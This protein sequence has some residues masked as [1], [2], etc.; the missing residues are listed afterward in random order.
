M[1]P[2]QFASIKQYVRLREDTTMDTLILRE[3]RADELDACA[4]M[5][6]ESFLTVAEEFGLTPE[7][8]ATNG[9]FLPVERLVNDFTNGNIMFGVFADG[10]RPVGFMQ[11]RDKGEGVFSLE[12]LCVLPGWR[13]DGIGAKLLEKART[14]AIRL[15]GHKITIGIIE[16]NTR[17][18]DWYLLNGFVHTGTID[19][20]HLPFIVG[21][22]ELPLNCREM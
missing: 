16:E 21:F 4:A 12:K 5:I 1:N 10:D 15:G 9:A 18:K 3:V 7:N 6:R 8:C 17:L 22:M 13:H 2:N 20:P 11:L 14:E 19:L